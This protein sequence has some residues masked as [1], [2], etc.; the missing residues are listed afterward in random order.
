MNEKPARKN[1]F[2]EN[3]AKNTTVEKKCVVW[4]A[5]K[6]FRH[7]KATNATLTTD[8]GR[9]AS[10][11]KVHFI[12][13]SEL[14]HKKSS[15]DVLENLPKFTRKHLCQSLLLSKVAG[16]ETLEQVFSCEFC[17]SFM[18]TMLHRTL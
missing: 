13:F 4:R 9:T 2:E 10:T 8:A 14:A 1:S 18:N 7:K 3:N 6:P 11:A 12:Y 16:N 15:R 5:L 17:E